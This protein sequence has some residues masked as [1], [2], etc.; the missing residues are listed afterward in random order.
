MT[1]KNIYLGAGNHHI[2]GWIHVDRLPNADIVCDITKG[3]PFEDDSIA[4]CYSQ[5]F[6]EHLPPEFAVPVINEIWRVLKLGGTMEHLIPNAGS[7]NDYGSPTH[8][9]HWN[10]QCFEH[11]DKGSYRWE[12]DRHY[13]GF[14]GAF[15]K[16]LAE[17][18]NWQV[19]D[20][21]VKRAQ[22]IHVVYRKVEV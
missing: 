17:L 4:K 8:L 14:I 12:L 13:E 5:D 16:E 3:L 6:M 15:E 10:L 9:T 7:R 21:G 1:D 20:D 19:E 22:S 11:F 18:V 2:D